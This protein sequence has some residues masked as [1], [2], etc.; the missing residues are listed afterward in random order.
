MAVLALTVLIYSNTF[1]AEFQL[2]DFAKV[3]NNVNDHLDEI[4]IKNLEKVVLQARPVAH[5]TFA[6]NYYLHQ[7]DV[8]GYHIINILIHLANTIAL[9]LFVWLTLNLPLNIHRWGSQAHQV[10]VMTSLLWAIHPV[11]TQA[12]TYIVQRMTL[13]SSL[14]YLV[15]LIAY[16]LARTSAGHIRLL[17]YAV[18]VVSF[19]LSLG[20][21]EIAVT[22][23][24]F[25]FLYEWYFLS[26]VF[27][28]AIRKAAW[29][30]LLCG[31]LTSIYITGYFLDLQEGGWDALKGFILKEYVAVGETSL[32]FYERTLTGARVMVHY[33]SLLL[34][35][36]PALL[37]LDYDFPGSHSMVDPWTT[38][39]GMI[40]FLGTFGYAIGVA[41]RHP[42]ISFCILWFYGNLVLESFILHLDLVFEHRLYLPSMG[43][44]FLGSMGIAYLTQQE[45]LLVSNLRKALLG[46]IIAGSVL[47]LCLWTYERNET[48]RTE[49]S[50]WEDVVK[51]SPKKARAYFNL[52]NAYKMAGM[53][54]KADEVYQ[55][56][57]KI[58]P[59]NHYLSKILVGRGWIHIKKQNYSEAIE[60]LQQA[61]QANPNYFLGWFN[62]GV[63][64]RMV[65]QYDLALI[66]FEQ[67]RDLN[68]QHLWNYIHIGEIYE[69][70]GAFEKAVESYLQGIAVMDNDTWRLRNK[71]AYL[72][73]RI[74]RFNDA[75]NEYRLSLSEN[76]N[77]P[78]IHNNLGVLYY[79]GNRFMEASSEFK[80]A[81]RQNP[82]DLDARN[83]LGKIYAAMG[84]LEMAVKEFS[85]VLEMQPSHPTARHNLDQALKS[86][87][88]A[89][90]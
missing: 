28:V 52:G 17:G 21:K 85:R 14:F 54:E 33:I 24:V 90:H 20:S 81:L 23:P 30:V 25:I 71:L 83:N 55:A 39:P 75:F 4:S 13:L 16:I 26:G 35:P 15:T 60:I 86:L 78:E 44:L 6:L 2:D 62:L 50:L 73:E 5:L 74:E 64:Y 9:Y 41:K 42:L 77:Q 68:S 82:T 3:K 84:N 56:G 58:E 7:S 19:P 36:H 47:F 1:Q 51:K 53:L 88:G 69:R 45:P 18:M 49:I 57:L 76:P 8:F 87:R 89:A 80:E 38:L 65:N 70:M 61:V 43:F 46:I 22:L 10:A 66:A 27:V 63:A 40:L 67:S 32:S 12:V 59:S 29:V 11:Q 34:F 48:W 72:Y 31:L 37:N 79:K